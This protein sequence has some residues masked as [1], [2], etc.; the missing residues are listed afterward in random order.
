MRL[1]SVVL[2]VAV[3]VATLAGSAAPAP[4]QE[5]PPLSAEQVQNSIRQAIAYLLNEQRANGQW[6]EMIGY[7][8][9]VTA[10]AT[11]ALLNAGVEPEHPKIQKSLDFLRG[12]KLDKTY[13]VAL[14]TMA[15]CAGQPRRDLPLIQENA[16]W[17]SRVQIKQ[18]E[19]AGS[20]SYGDAMGGDNSNS[21]FAVLALHEAER[22]GA[23]VDPEVWRL[24]ADYW[25]GCQEPNGSWGYQPG[26]PSTGSM[27]AAG[28]GAWVIC[29]AR[30]AAPSARIA[31]ETAQCC[32]PAVED[33]VLK[34]A[35]DWMG[36][37][38]SVSRNPGQGGA[39]MWHLYYLYGLERVGRLSARRFIGEH[40][41]YREGAELL[42]SRQDP[43][44]HHWVGHHHA[45]DQP[46]IATSL[47]LLFLSKGRWPV[48]VAKL[49]HGPG[50]DWNNHRNDMPNI[51]ALC[52]QAWDLDL[53]WQVMDPQAAAVED[54]LQAPVLFLTGSQRPELDGLDGKI[55][56]YI[57]R[58]GF[59]FAEAC[60][61]DGSEFD[62]GFR[63]FLD[64]VFPEGEYKLRRVGPE[65]P[66]WKTEK[67]VRP[68]SPYATRLW[69]VEYGCRT[70]V[71]FCEVDL[72]C[73]WELSA[74]SRRFAVPEGLK[75]RIDDA[76]SI[77][78]N[79]LAYATNREPKGKEASFVATDALQLEG[80][81]ARNVI[82]IG[83]LIHGGG[84][85]DA[86]GALIN[87][88]RAAAQ[89]ELKL[90]VDAAQF[91]V[92]PSDPALATQFHMVFMHGR[93]DF[94]FTPAEREN[95]RAYLTNGGMLLGDA[96]CASKEFAAAFRRELQLVMPDHRLERIPIDHPLFTPAAGG[97][98]IREVGRREPA[99]EQAGQPM[100][101]RVQRVPPELEG[102][103]IDGRLA[104]IFSP[105]DISCALEHHEALQCRGYTREDAARIGLNAILY[106][107]APDAGQ[108]TPAP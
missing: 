1:V 6:D 87:L 19:R 57:D 23:H 31:G 79:V 49:K 70:C 54:L 30:V 15:L 8:G 45:E 22:A 53:T 35:V 72:S 106:S 75:Q 61:L 56:A 101:A 90:S 58:G 99:A 91:D 71:V 96:I 76:E 52:E 25:K 38:F 20:W 82:R 24:A 55:R 92:L 98:D 95:L 14:Q 39:G 103:A 65:H 26:F 2:L 97:F 59:L 37:N 85:N 36:R 7:E 63:A 67:L 12:L 18:G 28:I 93:H 68:E 51:T 34:R 60:C 73:Y 74:E 81:G 13:T 84:C 47:A 100:R 69:S 78:L 32:M 5:L 108:P 80:L 77:G 9:G 94:R 66:I 48:L 42:I 16:L 29:S 27:T 83:K 43:F 105:Y 10:L 4:A 89:G 11:L 44:S 33:D 21:Q 107:L 102:I 41:W 62:D 88:L 3:V 64:R 104:V 17:L 40:D 86:P 46:H 50:E